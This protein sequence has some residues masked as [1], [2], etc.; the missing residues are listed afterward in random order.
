MTVVI[1]HLLFLAGL[2]VK[3]DIGRKP[4]DRVVELQILCTACR[5]PA[6]EDVKPDTWY[7]IVTVSYMING[8]DNFDFSFVKP[9]DKLDTG[10]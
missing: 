10:L 2:R 4:W 9:E 1:T 6:F 8:G 3:Y 7:R 5:V